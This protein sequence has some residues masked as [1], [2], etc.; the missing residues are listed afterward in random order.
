[1]SYAYR[2]DSRWEFRIWGWLPCAGAIKDRDEFLETLKGQLDGDALWKDV[3]GNT[4][5]KPK[6]IEWHAW[7]CDGIDGINGRAYLQELLGGAA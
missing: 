7:P 1:V 5:V 4:R 3:F 6:L 2:L